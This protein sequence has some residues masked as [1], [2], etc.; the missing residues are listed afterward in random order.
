MSYCLVPYFHPFSVALKTA[1]V[2]ETH[3]QPFF[4]LIVKGR[5]TRSQSRW[6]REER[7]GSVKV[8]LSLYPQV[9]YGMKLV[10]LILSVTGR[11]CLVC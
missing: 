1:E 9:S 11:H 2:K 7:S 4:S 6:M 8:C 10:A 3:L 5:Q